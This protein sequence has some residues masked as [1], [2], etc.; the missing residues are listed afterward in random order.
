MENLSLLWAALGSFPGLEV[1]NSYVAS[2]N[3]DADRR[4]HAL[5]G[6]A[7]NGLPHY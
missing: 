6:A 2:Q 5:F 3:F 1:A 4:T 7:L